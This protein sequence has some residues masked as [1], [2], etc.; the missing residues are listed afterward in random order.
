MQGY[1][2]NLVKVYIIY[3]IKEWS[4]E[5]RGWG[6]HIKAYKY[7]FFSW[8]VVTVPALGCLHRITLTC[9]TTMSRTRIGTRPW[10]G[11]ISVSTRPRT[12]REWGPLAPFSI[13]LVKIKN[14]EN[15]AWLL[16]IFWCLVSLKRMENNHK[17][18]KNQHSNS[19]GMIFLLCALK[20]DI[21]LLEEIFKGI[22]L[23]FLNLVDCVPNIL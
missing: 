7:F 11:F 15:N 14:Q 6:Y 1:I 3:V 5:P 10:P 4:A 12:M 17:P 21:S 9:M 22:N 13:Y 18:T 2:W 16:A 8:T 23:K 20:I 19:W